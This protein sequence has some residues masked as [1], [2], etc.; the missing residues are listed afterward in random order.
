[1]RFDRLDQVI[2]AGRQFLQDNEVVLV[3]PDGW[4]QRLCEDGVKYGQQIAVRCQDVA[5]RKGKRTRATFHIIVDRLGLDSPE[6]GRYD[7]L[8]YVS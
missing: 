8:C 1:M 3:E 2:A 4:V 7:V 5:T 6:H